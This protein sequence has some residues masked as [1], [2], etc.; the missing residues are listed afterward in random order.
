MTV[1]Q[2]HPDARSMEAHMKVH[3]VGV[4]R[5]GVIRKYSKIR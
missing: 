1:V 4:G 3:V 2:V 5:D